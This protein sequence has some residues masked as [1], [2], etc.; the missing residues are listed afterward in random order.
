M[1]VPSALLGR[2]SIEAESRNMTTKNAEL[3]RASV[4]LQQSTNMS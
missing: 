4:S 2:V 3:R 1:P